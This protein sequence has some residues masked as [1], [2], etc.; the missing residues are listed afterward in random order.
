MAKLKPLTEKQLPPHPGD[1]LRER[2]D[3]LGITLYQVGKGSKASPPYV[4][5]LI[6]ADAHFGGRRRRNI[7]AKMALRL[8]RFFGD[9]PS[10]WMDLQSARSLAEE[11]MDKTFVDELNQVQTYTPP[12]ADP[13]MIEGGSST[14][15]KKAPK[16]KGV[17][18]ST[19]KAHSKSAAR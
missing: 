17:K 14:P 19:S 11:M 13:N 18:R 6:H 4:Y 8:A 10:Y 1:V 7:S 12:P 16:K 9:D 3:K 2:I 5:A 15:A